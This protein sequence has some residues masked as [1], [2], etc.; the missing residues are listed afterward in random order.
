MCCTFCLTLS[1]KK[2]VLLQ[3]YLGSLMEK[4]L[5]LR[6]VRTWTFYMGFENSLQSKKNSQKLF[7]FNFKEKLT[8]NTISLQ[9]LCCDTRM[10]IRSR[11][12]SYWLFCKETVVKNRL[13][14]TMHLYHERTWLKKNVWSRKQRVA[15][16]ILKTLVLIA[17]DTFLPKAISIE[18]KSGKR[19]RSS[20]KI[21]F[22]FLNQ[23][24]K[25]S[26]L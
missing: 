8:N 15:L 26:K 11:L 25:L 19:R 3:T 9:D 12:S 21:S 1:E 22:S 17:A 2:I 16:M 24:Q 23:P 10:V 18:H 4:K 14:R 7:V 13:F 20:C 5:Y 6:W